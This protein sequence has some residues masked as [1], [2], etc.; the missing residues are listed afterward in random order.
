M[1]ELL[2]V[3]GLRAGYGVAVVIE[4][5]DLALDDGRSLAVLGRNGAGKTTLINALIG[6][7]EASGFVALAGLEMSRLPS[8][9]RARAGLGWCP[10]ERN[11][12]RSLTVE[13]NLT[14]VARPGLWGLGRVYRMFPRLE[15]R[16]ANMG[17]QLSGGEQQMLAIG[18]ALM[19]NPKLLLLDEPTEG[20]APAIVDELLAALKILAAEGLSMIVVEQKAAK[21][22]RFADE[23][24]ILNRGAIVYRAPGAALL[25][26]EAALHRHLTAAG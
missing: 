21:I 10:Q 23:A 12:F 17:G 1:A 7:V 26:D 8:H 13:E 18:R 22:L 2:R 6:A 20:L 5:L 3:E 25:A 14:A 24:I 4:T 15:E 19:L 16:R 11:I 9:R